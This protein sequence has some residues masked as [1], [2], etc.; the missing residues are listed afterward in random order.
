MSEED[1]FGK[2]IGKGVLVKKE[3]IL[4]NIP[5][6]GY[7]KVKFAEIPKDPAVFDQL[8]TAVYQAEPVD[9]VDYIGVGIDIRAVVQEDSKMII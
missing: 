6:H 3:L 1:K 5:L 9:M 4:S 7:K 2:I 8:T